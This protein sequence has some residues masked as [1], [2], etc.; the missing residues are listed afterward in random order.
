M[1]SE[2][3][4]IEIN[5]LLEGIYQKYGYDFRDYSRASIKR[6]VKHT[7]S[8]YGLSSI[9]EMLH[10]VLYDERF[11][12]TLLMNFSINV[13]EM[14]RDPLFYQA[15]L[16]TV[17]SALEKRSFI[18]IWHAGCATG[19]EAYSMAIIL[20]EAGLYDRARIYATDFNEEVIRKA[21]EGI[22]SIDNMIKYGN[23]YS[24]ATGNNKFNKYY[25]SR[26]DYAIIDRSLRKNIIFSD[27]NLVTDHVFCEMDLIVCRNVLIYFNKKLQNRVIHLFI[28]SLTPKGYLCLGLQESIKFTD[29]AD[30]FDEIAKKEKIYQKID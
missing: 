20:K 7:L 21:R 1:N 9:S 30:Y 29:Y 18:R 5:L 16:K 13:T 2:S 11:F 15:L 23:N 25:T 12:N 24:K 10:Q 22:Y 17:I 8:M 4:N 3:E 28:D 14:F 19:E 26:Y 27:Y 6:R